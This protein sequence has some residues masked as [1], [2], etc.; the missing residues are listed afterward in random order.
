M[1]NDTFINCKITKLSHLEDPFY[2]DDEY[3]EGAGVSSDFTLQGL[4]SNPPQVGKCFFM[5]A[6]E[7][8]DYGDFRS[9]VVMAVLPF[10]P[11]ETGVDKLVLP[12]DFPKPER[13]RVPALK[14]G[15]TLFATMNSLYLYQ[16]LDA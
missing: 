7:N 13:L 6:P 1:K 14:K 9:S 11:T 8:E 16:E 10:D 4:C 15:E 12:Q 5:I 3:P 2:K